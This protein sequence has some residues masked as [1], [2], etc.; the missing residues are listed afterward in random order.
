PTELD[1]EAVPAQPAAPARPLPALE[2]AQG[3]YF[4]PRGLFVGDTL[5]S[6][7]GSAAAHFSLLEG[8][9]HRP[10]DTAAFD[11]DCV[12]AAMRYLTEGVKTMLYLPICYSNIVGPSHRLEYERF[13]SILPAQARGQLAASVYDVP[14]DP[15]F[16]ALSQIRAMLAKYVTNIDLGTADPGFEIEK[17]QPK[18]V[19]SVTLELPDTDS[20]SRFAALRRFADRLDLYK[21]KEIW[22][23]VTNVRTRTELEACAAAKVPFVT[24]SAVCRLQ[25]LPVGGRHR[26]LTELPVLA[27]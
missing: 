16:G 6:T 26:A 7:P 14:R 25:T 20:R 8:A 1:V 24:G 9:E 10:D 22:P 5:S 13:L 27:A 12:I 19:T 23:A 15:S 17:L 2:G 4:I 3:V 21:R 18:A 11:A